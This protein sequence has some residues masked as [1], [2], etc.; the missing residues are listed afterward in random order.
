MGAPA[1]PSI[2]S[3]PQALASHSLHPLQQEQI[4]PPPTAPGGHSWLLAAPVCLDSF[5]LLVSAVPR[6]GVNSVH[7]HTCVNFQI[8]SLGSQAVPQT[9][10]TLRLAHIAAPKGGGNSC[11]S[12]N[13]LKSKILRSSGGVTPLPAI[14]SGS[15]LQ[16]HMG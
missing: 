6:A 15:W 2:E 3:Q 14:L 7:T 12:G 16:W 11:L 4:Q 1:T 5:R 8:L 10:Q 9:S 13:H